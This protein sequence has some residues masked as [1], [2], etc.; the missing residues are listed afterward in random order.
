MIYALG[1]SMKKII[2][3]F[4]YTQKDNK[5]KQKLTDRIPDSSSLLT[6]S[7]YTHVIELLAI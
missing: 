1:N 6:L 3:E 4:S 7:Y 2:K 5:L